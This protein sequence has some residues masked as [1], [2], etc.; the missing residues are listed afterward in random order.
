MT[1]WTSSLPG[2]ERTRHE[3]SNIE[4]VVTGNKATATAD[5]T[6]NHY[7]KKMFWQIAGSYE[8]DLVKEDGQW[9]SDKMTFIA[10]S[11]SGDSRY[12]YSSCRTSYYQ[13]I[14]SCC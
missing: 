1:Q 14:I 11:E 2:F 10:E 12:Y 9:T 4:A 8:Y 3:I 7:L 5:V 6:A 13:W